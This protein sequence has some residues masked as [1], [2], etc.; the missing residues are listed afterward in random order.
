MTE[1]P[2]EH[3]PSNLKSRTVFD[4]LSSQV[5]NP[6]LCTHC[7]T[8]VGLS[9]GSLDFIQTDRGPLPMLNED[10]V[11]ELDPLAYYACPGKGLDYPFL[12][13]FVFKQQ[14]ENFFLGCFR[15]IF[16]G[17]SR[18]GKI[19]NQA[20]SGGIITQTLKYLLDQNRV[21]GAVVLRHG[22]P[23]PWISSPIIAKSVSEI[24]ASSQSVYVPVPTNSIFSKFGQHEGRL[25]YVGMPDQVASLR[26][27]QHLGHPDSRKVDFVIG[28]YM[29]TSIYLEAIQSFMRANGF[30]DLSDI[31]E[32]R[33]RHGEWP[34]YLRIKTVTGKVLKAEKFYYNYLIPFYITLSSLLSVD[35]TNELTDISVG[36]AWRPDLE[37]RGGGYSVVIARSE[38]GESILLEMENKGLLELDEITANQA[39]S[40]HAHMLDFKKRGSFIRLDRLNRKGKP[41][42]D[43]GYQPLDIPRTRLFI[44]FFISSIFK[45]GRTN[46]ARKI[47]EQIP[48]PLVGPVFNFIRKVWK[49]I[50]VGSKRKSLWD[51]KF[52]ANRK[53]IVDR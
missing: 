32:L 49:S 8:C 39:M 46:L 12:H 22:W 1:S 45:I 52:I 41:V 6:G 14:P 35:F 26:C 43:F 30:N 34:G 24:I 7:G 4:Q 29:G 50:S 38:I 19:R 53:P 20:A 3:V 27:L 28:P 21:T 23:H 16:I 13:E 11:L 48:L 40:M 33:Y 2:V 9:N 10:E 36:D 17:Y 51:Q 18:E 42:P 5:I 37:K 44:E 47:I 31:A 25:A 15:K